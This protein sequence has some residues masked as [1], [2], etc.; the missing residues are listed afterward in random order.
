MR[1]MIVLD[2][3]DAGENQFFLVGLAVA[4]G[5]GERARHWA[6]QATSTR[7]P[8]TQMPSA[9]LSLQA[10]IQDGRTCRLCR[11]LGVFKDHDAIALR[12]K[13]QVGPL[14]II[15]ALAN[16]DAAMAS[17]SMSAGFINMVQVV[18]D[19]GFKA[20]GEFESLDATLRGRFGRVQN[21]QSPT[22]RSRQR[23]PPFPVQPHAVY[24]AVE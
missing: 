23:S 21:E 14:A 22:P 3:A 1:R 11:R 10:L 6:T 17:T 24:L 12:P 20:V 7:L 5:V 2:A 15:D 18:K 4:I 13:R 9:E 8:S 16:P 19:R